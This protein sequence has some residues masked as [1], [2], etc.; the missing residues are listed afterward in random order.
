MPH[1]FTQIAA[2]GRIFRRFQISR[3]AF[4][5][6][7]A[8]AHARA[9]ADVD[10]VLGA[11]DGVFVMLHHH[12]RVALAGERV[13]RVEQ[14]LVVARVQADGRLIEH[15][16]H[17]LQV[18]AQLRR[19]ANALRLAAAQRR[20]AAIQREVAQADLCEEVEAALDLGDQIAG[21]VGVAAFELQVLEP[22][23][24]IVHR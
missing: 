7:P 12:Q 3:R 10:Q 13:Q 16:A 14:Y 8:T 20:R 15:V 21:D 2:G 17:A 5:H 23:P 19:Q 6:Q 24:Q 1:R 9:G 18:A 11:A 4:G 22:R